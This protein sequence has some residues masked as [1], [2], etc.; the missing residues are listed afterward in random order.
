MNITVCQEIETWTEDYLRSFRKGVLISACRAFGIVVG[1]RPTISNIISAMM[2]F[3]Q[4][5]QGQP[6]QYAPV[7]RQRTATDRRN[8]RHNPLRT[9]VQISLSN[10]STNS[11]RTP[12]SRAVSDQSHNARRIEQRNVESL[13]QAELEA[14]TASTILHKVT[15]PTAAE[16]HGFDRYPETAI[17]M[18]MDQVRKCLDWIRLNGFSGKLRILRPV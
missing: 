14:V 6:E 16:L 1:S 12:T 3:Q 7:I 17:A 15:L 11:R 8:D 2:S 4:Q 10:S 5:Q 18:F 13:Q 9:R